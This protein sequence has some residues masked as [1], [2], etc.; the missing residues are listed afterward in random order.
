MDRLISGTV[1]V[2]G[3]SISPGVGGLIKTNGAKTPTA[4]DNGQTHFLVTRSHPMVRI[5]TPLE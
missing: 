1:S 5:N 4:D 3:D 2:T